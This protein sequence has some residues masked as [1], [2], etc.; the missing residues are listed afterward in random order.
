M[1]KI[2]WG[3][4]WNIRSRNGNG[5]EI[6]E[7]I[8]NLSWTKI[9]WNCWPASTARCSQ[10]H[11]SVRILCSLHNIRT[12][13]LSDFAVIHHHHT[14]THQFFS[15]ASI[16]CSPSRRKLLEEW[17]LYKSIQFSSFSHFSS[18]SLQL[19]L[20][21]FVFKIKV[22]SH[23]KLIVLFVIRCSSSR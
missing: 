1:V 13:S 3:T 22:V 23:I 6:T 12:T 14:H 10:S 20:L 19:L 16:E 11:L 17:T 15:N 18:S 5:Y 8:Y 21:S 2:R 4:V 9:S 7:S